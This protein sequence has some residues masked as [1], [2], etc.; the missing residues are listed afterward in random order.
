MAADPLVVD[1]RPEA[2]SAG[3][4][5][6]PLSRRSQAR[7]VVVL[8]ALVALG[9]LTIDM[10]LPALPQIESDLLTTPAAVQLTLTGTL[11][12]LGIGQLLVGPISD[13]IGRRRPLLA[14]IALHV[15][16]SLLCVVAPTIVV[17]G[18]LRVVQGLGIAAAS[19]VATAVVRDLFSGSDVARILSRLMLVIGV[20]PVLAPT[21]GGELL[22]W[23]DWRGIFVAL[24]VAGVALSAVAALALPESLPPHRRLSGGVAATGRVYQTLLRDRAF[25]ALVLVAGFSM[26]AVFAYVAGASFVFQRQ[27][28]LD[29][30][31]FGLVFGAG[32]LGLIGATQ[33]NVVLLR[34]YTSERILTGAMATGSVAGIVLVLTSATGF[35]GF[36]GVLL[37]LWTVVAMVGFSL[38]NA[39]ALALDA[40][41]DTA[42]TA[43][44]LLG[45]VQF[46]V[47]ALSAPLVGLLGN[48]SLAMGIVVTGSMVV[49]TAALLLVI[50]ARRGPGPA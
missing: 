50:G 20:A 37:P 39:P 10:Y 27:Y 14:G 9:P 19:V 24:A 48:D 43:S 25:V 21:V 46:G 35:G 18:A 13:A 4:S 6:V 32:A 12:G 22:R 1:Q 15:V 49:G 34:R 45:A 5:A 41:G 30:Q 38:P 36:L 11:F 7:L 47:G 40:H 23:T 28:G 8:G 3:S 26:A 31:M 17:L 29:E 2:P 44:A 16:A 33:L 42:G